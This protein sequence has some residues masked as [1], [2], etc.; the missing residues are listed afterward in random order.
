[1]EATSFIAEK[2]QRKTYLKDFQNIFKEE[3]IFKS[4]KILLLH[5]ISV[6]NTFEL[7]AAKTYQNP[8]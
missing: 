3:T 2:P 4:S 8:V 1:M 7:D 6:T 5:Q